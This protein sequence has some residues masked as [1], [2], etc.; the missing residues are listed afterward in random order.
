MTYRGRSP[1]DLPL[2]AYTTGVVHDEPEEDAVPEPSHLSQQDAVALAMGIEPPAAT[3]AEP[4]A[5]AIEAGKSRRPR[6]SLPRPSLPRPPMPRLPRLG[7][8]GRTAVAADSPF[9][10]TAHPAGPAGYGTSAF[11]MPV[12]QAPAVRPFAGSVAGSA[13]PAP[14][15]P[16]RRGGLGVGTLGTAL[17]NPRA[18]A[19]D[20]RVLFG[21]IIAIGAVLLG[22]S[23]F[24]GGNATGGAV[25]GASASAAPGGGGPTTPGP[26]T[27]QVAGD[28]EAT[29]NLT[30]TAGSGK[31]ADGHL[32]ATWDDGAGSSVV[33]TGRVGGTRTTTPEL[34][35]AI[36]IMRNGAPVTFT[37]EA[38]ECTI[39]MAEKM[40]NVTGSFV[41]PEITSNGGRF[42]VKL[43]GTYST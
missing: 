3:A 25:P 13:A 8:R 12:A 14:G 19:R 6:L 35:L 42:T 1:D 38:G 40:F 18:A 11:A 36:T 30:G 15:L 16:A 5:P 29:L 32:A 26:A 24:G 27:M 17:R 2:A 39:G 9:R 23:M 22:V 4:A 31:P 43:S 21:G 33:L 20:P 41:C 7:G 34:T 28:F 10:V 37:S